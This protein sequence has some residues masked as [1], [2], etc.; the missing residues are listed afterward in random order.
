MTREEAI[1]VAYGIPVTKAQHEALQFLI[2]ELAEN[3]DEKIRKTLID[4]VKRACSKYGV[5]LTF[6]GDGLTEEK[7]LAYLEKQ[8]DIWGE[9]AQNITANML[10]DGIEGIQRELIEFLS[11]AVNASW[12]DIIQSAD[13]YA[14]R[15]RNIIEKQKEQKP[16]LEQT[17]ESYKISDERA[18]AKMEGVIEGRQD[19]IKHPEDYGL[20]EQKPAEWSEEDETFLNS[21]LGDIGFADRKMG[22]SQTYVSK[23]AWFEK[24]LGQYWKPSEEQMRALFDASERNDKLGFVLSTLYNDL[25]KL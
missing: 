22:G 17:L 11:N 5:Q 8:K 4:I 21:I 3:E 13:V 7:I 18:T 16:A 15:I 12:V 2:P 9:R 25:K 14:E 24:K 20:T 1:K 10:E 23:R 6:T 19:V